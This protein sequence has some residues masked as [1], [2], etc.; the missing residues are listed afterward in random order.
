[1]KNTNTNTKTVRELLDSEWVSNGG[2]ITKKAILN[3]AC[4]R[5]GSYQTYESIEGM[6]MAVYSYWEHN[7]ESMDI[8]ENEK[9]VGYEIR[10][11]ADRAD[12]LMRNYGR[13][14]VRL[15]IPQWVMNIQAKDM[16]H[17]KSLF[18]KYLQRL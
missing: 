13:D 18:N 4:D 15:I 16:F 10:V 8:S 7:V 9:W 14:T 12:W 11:D 1:M 17:A 3:N 6:Y 2:H 5:L